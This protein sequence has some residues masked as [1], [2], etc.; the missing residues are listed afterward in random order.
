MKI[1][2]FVSGITGGGVEQML[3][4]YTERLN[5]QKNYSEIIVYQ[6]EPDSVC[7]RKLCEAGNECIRIPSKTSHPFKNLIGTYKLIKKFNPDIVHCHMSL[8][9][10]FPL[11]VAFFCGVNVRI[12]HSHISD[13]NT[14][15]NNNL[16]WIF[17]RL[18]IIFA[19]NLFACGHDAGRFLYGRKKFR[20][21][22]NAID[23]SRFLPN[24]SES[25]RDL[26][27]GLGIPADSIIVG[28]IGRFV[29]QKNH[30]RLIKIFKSFHDKYTNSVLLLIGNGPLQDHLKIMVNNLNLGDSVKFL[31]SISDVSEYYHLMDVFILPSLYEGLPLVSIEAQCA[32]VP[33]IISDNVDSDVMILNTTIS[34]SLDESNKEWA[35]MIETLIQS[36]TVNV[37]DIKNKI[38]HLGF[39][40]DSE[41]VKLDEYYKKMIGKW[42]YNVG[43]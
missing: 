18:N 24:F 6:H 20:V 32:G 1:M 25:E 43:Y 10:F 9:N 26:R 14:G 17:K 19:T 41:T 40:I 37:G 23:T 27:K 22:R 30:Q 16:I 7:L 5:T 39:E 2:H 38:I 31:G 12:S 34:F 13:N 28:N 42:N 3:I 8:L 33:M 21:I 29:K 36:P 4:N 35:R 15:L 11:M